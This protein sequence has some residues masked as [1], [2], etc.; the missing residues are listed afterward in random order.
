MITAEEFFRNKIKELHPKAKNITLHW[1]TIT[2]EQGLRWA[3]EYAQSV[4]ATIV[5]ENE[6]LKTRID[7]GRHYLMGVNPDKLTVEDTLVSLGFN[8]NGFKS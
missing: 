2:A 3:H 6:D 1:E 4:N 5:T 8:R 7:A